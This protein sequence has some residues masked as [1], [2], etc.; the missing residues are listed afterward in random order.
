MSRIC[1]QKMCTHAVYYEALVTII[2]KISGSCTSNDYVERLV[3]SQK[4]DQ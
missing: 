4:T 2:L 1:A 3:G